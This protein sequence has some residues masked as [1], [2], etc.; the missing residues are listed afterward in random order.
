MGK[1]KE[2][3]NRGHIVLKNYPGVVNAVRIEKRVRG[4]KK[5]K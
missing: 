5:E 4:K 1:T 2:K 3:R